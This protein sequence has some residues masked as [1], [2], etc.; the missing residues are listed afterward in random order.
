MKQQ[1]WMHPGPRHPSGARPY[2]SVTIRGQVKLQRPRVACAGE[3]ESRV[4]C[5]GMSCGQ[6]RWEERGYGLGVS[7]SWEDSCFEHSWE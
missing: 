2:A 3:W 7:S 5:G 4:V 1:V 6:P